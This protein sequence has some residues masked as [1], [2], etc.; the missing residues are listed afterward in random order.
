MAERNILA[1]AFLLVA[2]VAWSLQNEPR[3]YGEA[4]FGMSV[5]ATRRIFPDLK[6]V[7]ATPVEKGPASLAIY[8]LANQ[9]FLGLSACDVGFRFYVDQLY[10]VTFDCGSS[11]KVMQALRKRFG[12]P[13]SLQAGATYWRGEKTVIGLIEKTHKFAFSDIALNNNVQAALLQ[14]VLTQGWKQGGATGPTPAVTP[15]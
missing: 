14:Y 1:I 3:G 9:S 15:Q 13:G 8:S 11:E 12:E 2:Q 10:E 5:E 6:Q 4:Q 7:G